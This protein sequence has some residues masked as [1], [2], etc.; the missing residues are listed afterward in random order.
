MNFLALPLTV[1]ILAS[2]ARAGDPPAFGRDVAPILVKNCLGCHNDKKAQGGL[3][4]RTF[5]DLKRGG[6]TNGADI[7]VPNRPEESG[8]IESIGDDADPRM[9]YKLPPLGANDRDVLARWVAA[10]AKFDGASADDTPIATLVDPAA[11]LAKIAVKTAVSDPVTSIAISPDGKSAAA[12][13]GRSIELYDL[14]TNKVTATLADGPG[15]IARLIFSPDGSRLIAAGGRPGQFGVVQVW[16]VGKK[17]LVHDLRG[18]TDS[19]LAAD[20]A[21]DGSTLATAGYDRLVKLWDLTAG[22]EIRTLKEHTDAIFGVAFSPDGKLLASASADRTIKL[23]EVPSGARR[24]TIGDSTAEVY[25]VAFA[26]DGKSVIGAGVDRSIRS[27][28]LTGEGGKLAR[29]A[30]AHDAPIIHLL[31]ARDGTW[32]AS[33]SEDR[34]VKLWDLATLQPL[35]AFEGQGDWPLAIAL[36]PDKLRLV[37]GRYD[38]SIDSLDAST[39]KAVA[40]LRA[41]AGAKPKSTPLAGNPTLNPPSPRGVRRGAKVRATLTG[42]GVGEGREVIF[43]QAG[44]TARVVPREK[45]DATTLDIEIEVASDCR[46]GVHSLAVRTPLGMTPSQL[47]AVSADPETAE[48]E[49]N[50]VGGQ[51][52]IAPLPATLTGAIDRPGDVDSFRIAG[53]AGRTLVFEVTAKAIGSPLNARIV[54]LGLDGTQLAESRAEGGKSDAVLIFAPAA[55]GPLTVRV[56]DADFGG[57]GA[58]VYRIHAGETPFLD[59]VFPLGVPAGGEMRLMLSGV[60]LSKTESVLLAKDAKPGTILPA[61]PALASELESASRLGVVVAQGSQVVESNRQNGDVATAEPITV[62]GG[63][64]GV[65]GEAGDE[66]VYRFEA[67]KG[68]HLIVETFGKR[69]GSPIDTSLVIL[70]DRGQPVPRAVLRPVE[71][72]NVAFRD[73]ASASRS[74][75]LTEWDRFAERDFVFAGRE[76]MRI[77]ELPRNPDDDSVMWGPGMARKDPGDRVAFLGTTPEHHPLGQPIY[78][79]EIHPPGTVF[80]RAGL[81]PV[82]LDYRNDDGGPGFGKDSLLL[83]DPPADGVYF[84]RVEETRGMGGAQFRYHLVVREPKPDFALS[85]NTENPNVPRG[86]TTVLQVQA[87]RLDGFRGP[88]DISVHGLPSGVTAEPSTIEA[89]SSTATILLSASDSAEPFSPPTWSVD[90]SARAEGSAGAEPI[91]HRLDPGGP[92]SG[93]VTVRPE[94]PLKIR[95]A[96]DAVTIHPGERI[97]LTFRVERTGFTN[98]VPIDVRNLPMGVRVLNIGLNGVLVTEKET[99]RSIFLY[100]EPWAEPTRRAFFAVGTC[101]A[102]GTDHSSAAIFLTVSPAAKPGPTRERP[103]AAT[104]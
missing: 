65:I 9:P 103:E 46:I 88:I 54:I 64:S 39:G 12:A 17:T 57:S 58:H 70:D 8:L 6:K 34:T 51:A 79:V 92:G 16:D 84:V 25:A 38:G 60:N 22:R 81:A 10:G 3:S 68:H 94:P 30:F 5:A 37:V 15:P 77:A 49:P 14:S 76:L 63:V 83:F 24:G 48:R 99:E 50:D 44:L 85:V 11:G 78:K 23:W 97:A 74:I 2:L 42:T 96:S 61:C 82:T 40:S 36:S 80:P 41:A 91:R 102:T 26:A 32:L 71:V 95:S 4:M 43:P 62:P 90:G 86:G 7:L 67:R 31:A 53:K 21:T 45:P 27:W 89:D 93:F 73:H 66:D 13:V 47:L 75:R 101:E 18:H 29:S 19:I 72:T 104:R 1:A 20:L 98:R 33:A 56:E 87:N 35:R 100:A 28:T 52:M 55:D 59:C 69:L